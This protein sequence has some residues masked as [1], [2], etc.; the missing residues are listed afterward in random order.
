MATSYRKFNP[1]LGSIVVLEQPKEQPTRKVEPSKPGA[2]FDRA[3][4]LTSLAEVGKYTIKGIPRDKDGPATDLTLSAHTTMVDGRGHLDIYHAIAVFPTNPSIEFSALPGD[5]EEHRKVEIWLD[6]LRPGANYL[7]Q[8]R[9]T[10]F[11]PGQF[12]VSSSDANRQYVAAS[13][14][15]TIPVLLY[16]VDSP[17]AL[18]IVAGQ[19]LSSWTF[20]D[21]TISPL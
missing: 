10:G 5:S 12:V 4:V 16:Q 21:V 8:I 3:S 7:A 1:K 15:L 13:P 11:A 2:L 18:V 6:G 14:G 19:D 9:V 20:H 17:I